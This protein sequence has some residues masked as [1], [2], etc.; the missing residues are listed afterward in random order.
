MNVLGRAVIPVL[1]GT[2]VLAAIF[3]MTFGIAAW[4][5]RG[6]AETTPRLAPRTLPVGRADS[7]AETIAETGPILFPG[8]N[9]TTGRRTLILDHQGDDPTREWRVYLAYADGSDPSCAVTQVRE[10]TRFTDC[11]GDDIDVT[12]L[13][14]PT[15]ACP[16]VE[17]RERISIGL[18][19]DVCR[20]DD[21][22]T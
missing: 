16:I 13:A 5:S 14:R 11:N 4:I 6:D 3:A 2:V 19:A 20:A 10:T 21:N 1:G 15:D 22:P 12:E 17:N 7:V 18:V 9:T 8:L